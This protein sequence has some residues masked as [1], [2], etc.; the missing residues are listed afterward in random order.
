MNDTSN[1]DLPTFDGYEIEAPIKTG[2]FG[3]VYKAR[4]LTDDRRVVAIKLLDKLDTETQQR[5]LREIS[6]MKTVPQDVPI[7]PIYRSG[8]RASDGRPYYV[9]PYLGGKTLAERIK[10]GTASE[11]SVFVPTLNRISK[12]LAHAHG[13]TE[14]IVHRDIKPG[15]ILFETTGAAFLADY[16]VAL[17]I[18]GP[19][20]TATYDEAPRSKSYMSPEQAGSGNPVT[21]QSDIYSLGVVMFE[22]LTGQKPYQSDSDDMHMAYLTLRQQHLEADVPKLTAV[23]E[24]VDNRW[25]SIVDKAM[26]KDPADRYA[27]IQEFRR[28]LLTVANAVYAVSNEETEKQGAGVAK[29]P[30]ITQLMLGLALL[31]ALFG[32]YNVVYIPRQIAVQ[33]TQTALAV[34]ATTEFLQAEATAAAAATATQAVIELTPVPVTTPNSGSLPLREIGIV[35]WALVI[36]VG[37]V[38]LIMRRR[39]NVEPEF[40]MNCGANVTHLAP[41]QACHIC[42]DV[43]RG[44]KMV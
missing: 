38:W 5:W 1:S 42:G 21:V 3:T 44:K 24:N 43:R 29:R 2:G 22:M 40:C 14:P 33:Q 7:V 36:V 11:Q 23:N 39:N 27:T 25:Q 34:T 37:I 8:T 32:A 13:Q 17:Y 9:M 19:D 10:D 35:L 4:E 31:A 30:W 26:A 18:D 6:V 15:N 41:G 16:G 20:L 28:D 12:A